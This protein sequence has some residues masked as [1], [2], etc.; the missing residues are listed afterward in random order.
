MLSRKQLL[1]EATRVAK[2]YAAEG[3]SLTLR[4]LYY[5]LVSDTLIPN[6]QNSYKRLGDVL[7]EARLRGQFGMDLIEDRGRAPS[8]SQH[9]TF[10]LDVDQAEVDVL[11]AFRESLDWVLDV[12]PWVGQSAYVSVW[13]EKDALSGVFSGV[14]DRLGVGLFACKGYPSHSALWQW[15]KQVSAAYIHSREIAEEAIYYCPSYEPIETAK[16][17]YF[18]DHDPDGWQIPRTALQLLNTFVTLYGLAMP[19]LELVRVALNM[20]QIEERKLP[21]FPAK[22]TSS[23]FRSYYDEHQTWDAWELDALKP[24]VLVELIRSTVANEYKRTPRQ[25]LERAEVA[26]MND[27]RKRISNPAWT[28]KLSRMIPQP[29]EA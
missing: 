23:R 20:D 29:E 26:A 24:P 16:I 19:K 27:L 11:Y 12:D 6:A 13:V 10:R 8:K 17:L 2:A 25:A 3:Y 14:C 28:E 21:P 9:T 15:L 18:G 7:S 1:G 5:A 4:Q 22:T